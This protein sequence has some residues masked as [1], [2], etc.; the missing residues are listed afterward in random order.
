MLYISIADYRHT[1]THVQH[2]VQHGVIR[3]TGIQQRMV[4]V[5]I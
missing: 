1:Y 5:Y 2:G 3:Y 4:T